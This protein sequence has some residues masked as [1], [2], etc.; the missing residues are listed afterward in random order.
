MRDRDARMASRKRRA[1][2]VH[3]STEIISTRRALS[4]HCRPACELATNVHGG[5]RSPRPRTSATDRPVTGPAT[6]TAAT[7][8]SSAAEARRQVSSI[9]S[10]SLGRA[11][12]HR[13][14]DFDCQGDSYTNISIEGQQVPPAHRKKAD[15]RFAEWKPT[16][17]RQAAARSTRRPGYLRSS[18]RT[19]SLRATGEAI[20]SAIAH[21]TGGAAPPSR[22]DTQ[23]TD[24][25]CWDYP[26]RHLRSSIRWPH[27]RAITSAVGWRNTARLPQNARHRAL[28]PA[29]DSGTPA[30]GQRHRRQRYV[31]SGRRTVSC[32]SRRCRRLS[33]N[34][35]IYPAGESPRRS[36]S[37]A[38][39][40][41]ARADR[42][43]DHRTR[44]RFDRDRGA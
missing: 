14:L 34:L 7:R 32:Y 12:N 19:V 25:G 16:R 4:V 18:D 43:G 31:P 41:P 28:W 5:I 36:L 17:P 8:A 6:G 1:D 33:R 23:I 22:G 15:P 44:G 13:T 26:I 29:I 40:A 27:S 39:P 37:P 9:G 42:K 10:R 24:E 30:R 38:N 35:E 21:T 2:R 3:Q 20:V 11:D